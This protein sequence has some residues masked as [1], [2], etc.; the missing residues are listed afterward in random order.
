MKI[1]PIA[2]LASLA[3]IAAAGLAANTAQAAAVIQT[4]S[5]DFS[6]P[7]LTSAGGNQVVFNSNYLSAAFNPF[8]ASL[9]TLNSFT[10]LWDF[11]V[12]TQFDGGPNL[13]STASAGSSTGGNFKFATVNYDGAG[14]GGFASGVA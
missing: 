4:K 12:K 8:N 2:I 14:P 7:A 13:S 9:G 5:F 3:F 6:T 10:V 1:K 11:S